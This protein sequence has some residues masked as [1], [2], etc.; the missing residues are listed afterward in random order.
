MIPDENYEPLHVTREGRRQT[1]LR[2]LSVAIIKEIGVKK[3]R[4]WEILE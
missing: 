4:S 1:L 2:V 3:H